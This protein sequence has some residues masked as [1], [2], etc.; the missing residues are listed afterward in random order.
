MAKILL[1]VSTVTCRSDAAT[2]DAEETSPVPAGPFR[3]RL[4]LHS[5]DSV[6]LFMDL[7]V[8]LAGFVD[9]LDPSIA[10]FLDNFRDEHVPLRLSL[11]IV[12]AA[13]VLLAVLIVWGAVAWLRIRSLRRL[14]RST[15]T[16]PALRENFARIDAALSASIFGASWAEYRA[17]LKQEE[18]S[19]LYLRHPDEY[20]GLH[21]IGNTSFP[22]RF[23]AAAHGY[24]IGIGLLLTFIGL[25]AALKFAAGGVASPDIEIAKQA[26]NALLSAASFKFMTSIAGLGCSLVLSVAARTMTYAIENAAHGLAHDL[27]TAM[28]PVF[29]ESLAYDQLAV[30][31]Q[32]LARLDRL[33]SGFAAEIATA[34]APPLAAGL[35]AAIAPVIESIAGLPAPLVAAM[36]EVRNEIRRT[37]QT[38]SRTLQEFSKE[39]RS[40]AGSEIK[41][42]AAKLAEIGGAIGQ[43][44]QH[45]GNSG[46]AFAEQTGLAASQL[47]NAATALR[48]GID[49][50]VAA[51]GDRIEALAEAL[52]RNEAL[53]AASA[54]KAAQGMAESIKGAGD[55]I[56]LRM[57]EATRGLAA[58]S[59]GLA[60]RV[61]TMLGGLDDIN[62]SLGTQ[63]D[64]MRQVVAS[65]D[66][67]KQ[68]L[69]ASAT[70]WTRSSAPVVAAVDA[71][72]RVA[73]E[74]RQV[75]DH[76]L[77]AQRE[78]ADMAKAV[79]ATSEQAGLVWESYRGRFETVDEDLK[80]VF[81]HLQD[82]T[83]TFSKE[84]MEFVG[85][86]DANLATGL[87]ALSVGT[88]ELRE[89]AETLLASVA[90]KAA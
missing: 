63:V 9:R 75:A 66:G 81:E 77:A 31:R 37:D 59:D 46:Q 54:T 73:G 41:Q 58:T 70:A 8:A 60:L 82:G 21:A 43:T 29:A 32:Q 3:T 4:V 44:Q 88:E 34:M 1:T 57:V 23:F 76:I 72:E 55:E 56:A 69:D 26:L 49:G 6:D 84:M 50:R 78:M 33:D 30:T 79:T 27:E 18:T 14:V 36:A 83:R 52:A 89:V 25:V 61:G 13:L 87:Q 62:R 86:L 19:I 68:A 2:G 24:F 10:A 28:V 39:M 67:A 74:L 48:D 17:C 35:D 7:L 65:L 71:S 80:L 20:F 53:F 85:S 22:A 11:A 12:A 51:V 16:R 64:S 45:I 42:L 38:L 5:K 15:R 47:L 40:S 90:R